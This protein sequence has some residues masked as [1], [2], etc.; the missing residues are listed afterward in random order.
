MM[1]PRRR[2]LWLAAGAAALC[3]VAP[4][5][6]ALQAYRARKR[7]LLVFAPSDQHPM[8]TR[9]RND[10]NGHRVTL[11]DRDIV[12]LYVVGG[13]LATELGPGPGMSAPALRSRFRVSEGAFRVLLLGKDG[14][15]KLES[16]TPILHTELI[17]A[18]DRTPMRR[19]EI[20]R[21]GR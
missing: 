14:G 5:A 6:Q 16:G 8:L 15:V 1:L 4:G 13:S 7:P 2:F 17:A 18:L 20:R 12:V 19:D 10:L 9:Q 3:G 21:T 11:Q